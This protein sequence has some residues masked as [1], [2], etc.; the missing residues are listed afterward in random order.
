M[1]GVSGT[2]FVIIAVCRV[3]RQ[4]RCIDAHAYYIFIA[5]AN[6]GCAMGTRQQLFEREHVQPRGV[7]LEGGRNS[8]AKWLGAQAAG[9]MT[10]QG[11]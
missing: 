2:P 6:T 3:A 10:W 4:C 8:L 5:V 1:T 7:C 9:R 11:L